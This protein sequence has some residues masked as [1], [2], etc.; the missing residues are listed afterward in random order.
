LDGARKNEQMAIEELKN[1]FVM[2]SLPENSLPWIVAVSA[3]EAVSIPSK[4]QKLCYAHLELSATLYLAGSES[5]AAEAASRAAEA[6]GSQT[7]D[8]R[9]AVD[10]ELARVAD[11]RD[12][13]APRV[14][15][16]RGVLRDW[17][18]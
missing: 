2:A 13:L 9:T 12:E 15:N 7:S 18:K 5:Q 14:D 17:G 4:D 6:C 1:K 8:I 10:W 11:E 3:N 16:Y